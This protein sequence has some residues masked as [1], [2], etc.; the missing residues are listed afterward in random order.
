[1]EAWKVES[2]IAQK[3]RQDALDSFPF[4][5]PPVDDH[6]LPLDLRSY[7]KESGLLTDGELG[8]VESDAETLLHRIRDRKLTS[9]EVAKAFCK[10]TVIAQSLTN[11]VTEV[12]F[13]E[14]LERAKYLDDYIEETGRV[15]GPLHGLPISL[16]DC[17]ITPPHPSSSGLAIYANSR[18]EPHTTST[19]VRILREM[20]AVFYVKSN[21][22]TG[23][24]M[25]E[26]MNNI[27]G[28]TRNPLHKNLATGGSSGGEAALIAL[29]ASPLGLGT[30]VGGSLRS[31]GGSCHLYCLKPSF[32]RF[33]TWGLRSSIPGLDIIS[34]VS[35]PMSRELNTVKLFAE[36]VLSKEAAPWTSDQRM[37]RIPWRK[38]VIQPKGRPLRF[39]FMPFNDGVVTCYPPVERALNIVKNILRDAG[40]DVI[41]WIPSKTNFELLGGQIFTRTCGDDLF[42]K[43]D[44]FDE[45][46][47]GALNMTF[48]DHK[49]PNAMVGPEEFSQMVPQRNQARKQFLDQWMAAASKDYGPIDGLISPIAAAPAA[50]LHEDPVLGYIGYTVFANVLDL[51]SM[52][53]PVTYADKKLDLERGD[54]WTPNSERDGLIQD[55]YDAAF[56]HGAPISLQLIGKRLEDEKVVEM[57][58]IVSR[59]IGFR[60]RA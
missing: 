26:T 44:T 16:K 43:L 3:R 4:K 25:P 55:A 51:P 13:D 36:I 20:G 38:D 10:A 37:L 14:G 31:P 2:T 46:L 19:I 60:H 32:G 56:Y 42:S 28:E 24:M 6:D 8:I 30:D 54:G 5:A 58:E 45:P 17:Y 34:S 53:F 27:W 7:P 11:C 57:V 48:L 15:V 18:T 59:L 40:H 35:G 21:V 41:D 33:P 9:V 50:P 23:M 22:P 1:M 52:T 49:P 39:A 29:R 12:L 47:L